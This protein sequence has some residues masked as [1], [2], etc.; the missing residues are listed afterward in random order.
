MRSASPCPATRRAY[1]WPARH[2]ASDLTDPDLP[3]MGLRVRLRA[4]YPTKGFPPQ[5]R[6]VLEALK[7]YGMIVA[8]NGSDWYVSGAPDPRWDNDDL[9]TLGRSAGR[10]SRSWTRPRS[11]AAAD[12]P[13]AGGTSMYRSQSLVGWSQSVSPGCLIDT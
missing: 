11:R 6:A 3:P 8:D 4:D 1:V 7:A 5:A 2:F 13:Q 10:R 9:H 12:G